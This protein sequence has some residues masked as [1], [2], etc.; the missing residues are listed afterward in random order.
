MANFGTGLDASVGFGQESAFNTAATPTRWLP[1][2]S[3]TIAR[4]KTTVQGMGLRAG[5]L[6]PFAAQ[7]PNSD[8]VGFERPPPS[9][10]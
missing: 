9:G 10:P 1:F 2:D 8:W 6:S 5:N 4:K 3:D 7:R